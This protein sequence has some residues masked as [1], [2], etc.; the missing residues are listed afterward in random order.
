MTAKLTTSSASECLF[1]DFLS[2]IEP[3]KV[4]EALKHPGWVDAM[5]EELNQFYSNKVWT[6]APLSYGKIAIG[7]KWVFKYKK[8]K[9]AI[10]T[11]NKARMV[12]QGYSQ[13]ER[14]NYD[15]TFTP[16]ARMEA[17]R[18]F[19]VFATYMN[20]MPPGFESSKFPDYVSVRIFTAVA[21]LFFSRGNF[22]HWQWELLLAVGT[23]FGSRNSITGSGNA[24]CILFPTK[25]TQS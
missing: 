5:Q 24:L 1:A 2:E 4:F 23:S 25:S 15:K 13:E 21:S 11:K 19:L 18:I 6:L 22:L 10:V 7:S 20:F 9:H 8:D 3:K 14:I 17:I 16:V 12:A